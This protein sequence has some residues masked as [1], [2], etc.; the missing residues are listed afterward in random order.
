MGLP[1][2]LDCS[3]P[4]GLQDVMPTLLDAAGV[5]VPEQCDGRSVLPLM[6]GQ[7]P[8]G[9]GWRAVLHGEHA[10]QFPGWD[11]MQYL[12]DGRRKYCWFT[13]SGR[14]LLFDLES[15]PGEA[16]NLLL[17]A[18][19]AEVGAVWRRRLIERL[20][21]R[22]EGYAEGDQLI[23]GRPHPKLIPGRGLAVARN[24]ED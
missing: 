2:A 14:E 6:R 11:G 24:Q 5:R 1:R 21:H 22:P 7:S 16:H 10:P 20:H 9:V 8:R 23:A 15:D 4:V 18:D 3:A 19:G 12:T 17:D 13:Q